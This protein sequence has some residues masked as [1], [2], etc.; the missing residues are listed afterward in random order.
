MTSVHWCTSSLII[1]CD[2]KVPKNVLAKC[3]ACI[4]SPCKNSATCE[5]KGGRGFLCKCLAGYHGKYCEDQI[6]ACY[7]EP[8][9]NGATC[10]VSAQLSCLCCQDGRFTCH[11]PRGFEGQRCEQNIDDCAHNKCQNGATCVDLINTYECKCP[12]LHIGQFCEEKVEFCS[13]K[14]NPCGNGGK[15]TRQADSYRLFHEFVVVPAP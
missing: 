2:E 13:K 14:L 8:C 6:D 11:C 9:L 10:K 15:C 5:T 7:G 3:D 1:R 12:P 4:D